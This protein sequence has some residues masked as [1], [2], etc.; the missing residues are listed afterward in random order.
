LPSRPA[1]T[2]ASAL[3]SS[4]RFHRFTAAK[5][6]S[7]LSWIGAAGEPNIVLSGSFTHKI[8]NTLRHHWRVSHSAKFPG[9][10]VHTGQTS[11]FPATPEVFASGKFIIPGMKSPAM[12]IATLADL[13][14][15]VAPFMDDK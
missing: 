2:H 11:G 3:L 14:L 12:A 8:K 6:K 5:R 9:M 10:A 7:P 1:G 4:L 13:E 15:I